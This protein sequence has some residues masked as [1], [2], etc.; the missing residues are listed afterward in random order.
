MK[1]MTSASHK[2]GREGFPH[3][4]N[5]RTKKLGGKGKCYSASKEGEPPVT[6]S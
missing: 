3:L 5:G 4:V 2:W 6:E 1:G